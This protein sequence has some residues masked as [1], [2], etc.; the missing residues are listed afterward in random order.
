M[1][2]NIFDVATIDWDK[3]GWKLGKL[4]DRY[5]KRAINDFVLSLMSSSMRTGQLEFDPY[6]FVLDLYVLLDDNYKKMFKKELLYIWKN[7]EEEINGLKP[8]EASQKEVTK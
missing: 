4:P 8:K 6:I 1:S 2:I 3:L 5:K 7:E